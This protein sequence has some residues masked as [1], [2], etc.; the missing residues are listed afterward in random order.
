MF[1]HDLSSVL[2]ICEDAILFEKVHALLEK[3][4]VRA[5]EDFVSVKRNYR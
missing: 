2:F 5:D 3:V 1:S 4:V